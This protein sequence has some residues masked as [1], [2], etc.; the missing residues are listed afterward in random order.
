MRPGGHET[1]AKIGHRG[2]RLQSGTR[3]LVRVTLTVFLSASVVL[4]QPCSLVR[5]GSRPVSPE[6]LTRAPAL[7]FPVL[8]PPKKRFQTNNQPRPSI[9][10]ARPCGQVISQTLAFARLI[11]VA[12]KQVERNFQKS[13]AVLDKIRDTLLDFRLLS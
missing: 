9:S 2:L 1:S 3:P 6:A 7:A 5:A 11:V 8:V 12:G 4:R 13:T 10:L